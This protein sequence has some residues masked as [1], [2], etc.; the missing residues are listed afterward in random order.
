M[1]TLIIGQGVAGS[2][3]AWELIKRKQKIRIIDNFHQQSSS[4]TAAGIINPVTGKRLALM[5]DFDM[6]YSCAK[7]VY[8][9]LEGHFNR[10]FFKE[11]PILRIFK[12]EEERA[13]YNKKDERGILKKYLEE[14]FPAHTHQP[15]LDDPLGSI[16]I[17][18]AA[19]V[20]TELLLNSFKEFFLESNLLA[21]QA[22]VYNDL[23]VHD[24]HVKYQGQSFKNII[25]CE[26][27]KAQFNPWFDWLPFNS[28][29]GE[30]LE[31]KMTS[32]GLP[33]AII[34]KGKWCVPLEKDRWAAGASYLWEDLNCEPTKEGRDDILEELQ[35]IQREKT[36]V[37]H[38]AA[39]RPVIKDQQPVIG[40]HPK[41]KN[42]GIFNGFGSKGFLIGPFYAKNFSAFLIN[43]GPIISNVN[44]ERFVHN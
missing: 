39:V 16:R 30:I 43:K 37:Q 33:D 26:G 11:V 4:L 41:M 19:V 2:F 40:M 32:D 36:V 21:R 15:F 14:Y 38:K 1:E 29:K 9:D 18:N 20:A 28:V 24:D 6:F 35:Y 3:L 22:F 7:E 10:K 17:L 5:P 23:T 8:R 44:I 31:L 25:F 42:I 27:F 13:K 34:N 12:N